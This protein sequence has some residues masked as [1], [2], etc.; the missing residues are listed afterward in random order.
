MRQQGVEHHGRGRVLAAWPLFDQAGGVDHRVGPCPPERVVKR[1]GV[2]HVEPVERAGRVEQLGAR[3]RGEL[4]VQDRVRI[5]AIAAVEPDA[6]PQHA[7]SAEDQDA[8]RRF[9]SDRS[10][11]FRRERARS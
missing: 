5:E 8:H 10:A 2:G 3:R 7:S 4:G 11:P 6:V 9:P 1:G